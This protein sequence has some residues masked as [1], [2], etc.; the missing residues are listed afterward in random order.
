MLPRKQK[1]GLGK[2]PGL[3]FGKGSQ[4]LLE[5]NRLSL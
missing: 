2:A 5:G 1:L 3:I 4:S